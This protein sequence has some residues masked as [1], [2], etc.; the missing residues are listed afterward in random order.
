[1]TAFTTEKINCCFPLA[2]NT[3]PLQDE[4]KRLVIYN[5]ERKVW[6]VYMRHQTARSVQFDLDLHC[7][8]KLLVSSTVEKELM[9]SITMLLTNTVRSIKFVL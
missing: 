4:R 2:K 6:T 8:Q 1:M 7:P 5:L 3:L 9:H